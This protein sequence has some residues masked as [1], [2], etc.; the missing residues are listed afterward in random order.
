MT[1][2]LVLALA[3][4]SVYALFALG[5]VV[6]YKGSR[7]I[8]FAHGEVGMIG[9]F[10]FT[11]L[12]GAGLPL[13]VAALIGVL[14]AAALGVAIERLVARPL[15]G[16]SA[17]TAMV[18]TFAVSGLLLAVAVSVWNAY[19]RPQ[20]PYLN[21]PPVQ[22]VGAAISQQVFLAGATAAALLIALT[23]FYQRSSI[24]LKLRAVAQSPSGAQVVGLNVNWLSMLTWGLGSGLAAVAGI[25]ISPLVTFSVFFMT[26]L[27]VRGLA[28]ALLGGLTS[29]PLT[30]A[31]ALL[32]AE[33][34][35]LLQYVYGTAGLVEAALT[36]AVVGMLVLRPRHQLRTVG[37]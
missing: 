17:T 35:A 12:R 28:A 18:G 14:C 4:G 33:G 24:G 6:I 34:E 29:I 16:Q 8:N 3:T 10:V 37:A 32:L 11:S 36:V 5:L 7:I 23:W 2:V 21:G 27:L 25:L 26:A 30:V 20:T 22:F 31:A 13:I 15:S 9:T 1:T 19:P